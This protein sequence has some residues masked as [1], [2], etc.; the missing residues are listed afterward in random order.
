MAP[1]GAIQGSE[2]LILADITKVEDIR[3]CI[4]RGIVHDAPFPDEVIHAITDDLVKSVS[5]LLYVE[6]G[7]LDVIK[8]ERLYLDKF[9]VQAILCHGKIDIPNGLGNLTP[10]FLVQYCGIGHQT[11]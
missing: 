6:R 2:D 7:E 10:H 4:Y 8:Y 3:F 1:N 9:R 11:K 5:P